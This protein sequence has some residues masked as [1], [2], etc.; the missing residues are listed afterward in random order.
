MT[1]L[2]VSII[3]NLNS[4]EQEIWK[5]ITGYEGLYQ[6][7]N[8]GRVKS[9]KTQH[10]LSPCIGSTGYWM[11]SL[12]KCGKTKT[13]KIHRLVAIA[14]IPNPNNR[15]E[16][17]HKDENPLNSCVDN[18]EWVTT[19]E[20]CNMPLHKRRLS[21]SLSGRKD[22]IETKEKKRLAQLGMKSR[23]WGVSGGLHPKSHPVQRFT[24]N[25][26]FIDE[27]GSISDAS[28]ILSI[29]AQ[30]IS[31]CCVGRRKTAGGFIWKYAE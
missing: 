9:F 20:N 8:L 21:M 29:T 10:I 15:K 1:P 27:Y 4:M 19:K 7:S 23:L 14:F 18:L 13:W 3:Q 16:V 22:G 17:G 6:V 31:S 24:K 28:R 25:G 5:D 30:H 26:E 2:F 12:S 11:V